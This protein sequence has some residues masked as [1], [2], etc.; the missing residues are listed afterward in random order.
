MDYGNCYR[1]LFVLFEKKS[2]GRRQN[3]LIDRPWAIWSTQNIVKERVAL[4]HAITGACFPEK[5]PQCAQHMVAPFQRVGIHAGETGYQIVHG[6]VELVAQCLGVETFSKDFVERA[7]IVTSGSGCCWFVF[8]R[9]KSLKCLA[10][11]LK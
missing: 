8:H 10:S 1:M 11:A 2:T 9:S 3:Y 6:L 5:I 7:V 4:F